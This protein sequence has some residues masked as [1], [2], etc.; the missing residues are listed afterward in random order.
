M[1][2]RACAALLAAASLGGVAG[3]ADVA[4]W[5]ATEVPSGREVA[6]VRPATVRHVVFF[7]TWC[8]P[9]VAELPRLT[10]LEARYSESGY[11]LTIVALPTRHTPEQLARFWEAN[12][13]PGRLLFDADGSV[14]RA[15]GAEVV[16]THLLLDADGREILRAGSVRDGVRE[17][18]DARVRD[19]D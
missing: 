16:P 4:E 10:E 9:C 11:E 8:P 1:D 5:R 12:N 15:A 18:V 14:Q 13:V 3:A 19:R 2:V 7:A 17:A 6:V